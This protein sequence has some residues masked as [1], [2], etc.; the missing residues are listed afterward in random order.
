MKKIFVTGADGFIGSNL[1][2]KLLL[3]KYKIIAL[4]YY[5]SFN[6]IGWLRYVDKKLKKNL[7][8]ISG[9]IR[10][11][12]FINN[13][14]KQSDI[15]IHLAALIGIPYSYKSPKSYIDVNVTGTFNILESAKIN[16]IKKVIITSTSEVYGSAQKLPIDENHP[17]N[18]QSPYAASKIGAD[19]LS[20]SYFKTF[21]LPITIIR[22]FNTFGPRQ[23]MRAV[24]PTIINQF[25]KNKKSVFLGS[26]DT[27]RDFNFIDDITEGFVQ[28]VK[29]KNKKIFGEQINLGT[30][31]YY[32]INEIVK[33]IS[34]ISKKNIK[35]IKNKSE[36]LR[37]KNSEVDKLLACNKKAIKLLGYSPKVV[38]KKS[39]I[40][41]LRKTYEWY[42]SNQ[43]LPI[44]KTSDYAE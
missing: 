30:N 34:L 35:L 16:K 17:L 33:F 44:F 10:D 1:V 8:I 43:D 4:S 26:V 7:E 40:E 5:N 42:S 41:A 3:K 32:S 27:Y 37:P 22:P 11:F 2:Q 38:S 6:D 23:S 21:N 18:A 15:V 20:L 31:K 29:T 36:R 39:F 13:L 28:V 12:N 9:D 24:I 25:I 14:I 19:Q